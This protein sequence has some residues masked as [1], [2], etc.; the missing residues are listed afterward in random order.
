MDSSGQREPGNFSGEK[1]TAAVSVPSE[2]AQNLKVADEDATFK[3]DESARNI[4]A[5]K[6]VLAYI[7]KSALDEYAE[8]T[9]Q[10]IAE[11]FIEGE[12]ELRKIAVHQDHPD[13]KDDAGIMSGDD[14][15]EG[16]PTAD[17]SQRDGTV[18]FD[19]RFTAVL[20]ADGGLIEVLLNVEI[21]N[22]DTPRYP[23]PKRGIYYTSRMISSQRG[24]IFKDQEYEKIK[25]CVSIWICEGTADIRSDT[26]NRYS[27]TEE[28]LRGDFH[29]KRRNYDL[30]TVVVLRLG[31]KGENSENDAIRLLSK[32]FSINLSY[33]DKLDALQNEFKISVSR[34]MSEEVQNMC[35][36]STGVYS[37]GY[38]SGYGSGYDSGYD[39]GLSAGKM[40]QARET[41]YR[42]CDKGM[43]VEE[44]A[45]MVKVSM[46]TL[47]LWLEEREGMLV[48]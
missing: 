35:N 2:I 47:R 46:D 37:K 23:I 22:K 32:M 11:R 40:E 25:K 42:L 30:M 18:Y 48:K 31:S 5:Q 6:S 20:P 16:A 12:P 45:D 43:S 17:K 10:E 29:E 38:D 1:K 15:I 34:E 36:L 44:I 26:I 19:I 33:E 27:F 13:R 41:A 4:V 24:T 8:Y 28:C 3:Y 39:S 14:K 21:Q 9:V 7:L